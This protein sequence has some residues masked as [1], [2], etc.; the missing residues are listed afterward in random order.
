MENK[1]IAASGYRNF[2][3]VEVKE[4]KTLGQCVSSI[5]DII[6]HTKKTEHRN[7][8]LDASNAI[9]ADN[10]TK[11]LYRIYSHAKKRDVNLS[12]LACEHTRYST[13]GDGL[14]KI[15]VYCSVE[16][17]HQALNSIYFPATPQSRLK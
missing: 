4:G 7:I 3:F 15:P 12:L 5:E 14:S 17:Y 16:L 9:R 1:N 13:L 10:E 11:A 2:N 6:N 8:L